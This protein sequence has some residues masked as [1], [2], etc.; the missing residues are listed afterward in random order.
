[1]EE[2][3]KEYFSPSFSSLSLLSV[4]LLNF[5]YDDVD[6]SGILL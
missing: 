1:M 5:L 6:F 3:A 2:P 4:L